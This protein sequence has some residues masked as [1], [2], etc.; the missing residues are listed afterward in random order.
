MIPLSRW[1]TDQDGVPPT[2]QTEA[3]AAEEQLFAPMEIADGAEPAGDPALL[4]VAELEEALREA[5]DRIEQLTS[6]LAAREAELLKRFGDE[7]AVKLETD[8]LRA[9]NHMRE[10]TEAALADVLTPFLVNE[11]RERAAAAL[12]HLLGTELRAAAEPVLEIRTPAELH[13]AVAGVANALAVP[14]A[15]TAGER[16]EVVFS[17]RRARFEDLAARWRDIISGGET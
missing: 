2:L 12:M 11:A 7:L 16:L 10:V 9:F 4:R 14:A 8:V 1:L 6:S 15:I 17:G 5:E 13:A 3:P